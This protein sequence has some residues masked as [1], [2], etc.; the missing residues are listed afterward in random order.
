MKN[1]SDL[2][3]DNGDQLMYYDNRETV[4]NNNFMYDSDV[5]DSNRN[6]Y[7]SNKE[8][9]FNQKLDI[10][11]DYDYVDIDC[12]YRVEKK[13][14]N[15]EIEIKKIDLELEKI[16]NFINSNDNNIHLKNKDEFSKFNLI[17]SNYLSNIN[18]ILNNEFINK[19]Q[20]KKALVIQVS[21][22]TNMI[23]FT[24]KVINTN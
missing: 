24:E 23:K 16:Q 6:K 14:F 15:Y 22:L 17:N 3:L 2:N 21:L 13:L 7:Y 1:T 11:Q 19:E 18:S 10:S 5:S 8:V 12:M 4:F 20:T 9:N